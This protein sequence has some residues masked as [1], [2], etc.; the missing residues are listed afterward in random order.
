[1]DKKLMNYYEISRL[2]HIPKSTV[3]YALR[4]Y[5]QQGCRFVDLRLYNWRKA[6]VTNTK[7]KGAVKDYLLSHM[8]LTQWAGRSLGYRVKEL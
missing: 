8:T 4:R 6:W 3:H 2:L 7:I 5:E 1:M